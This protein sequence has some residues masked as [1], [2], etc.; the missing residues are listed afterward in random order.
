MPPIIALVAASTLFTAAA[1]PTAASQIHPE[2]PTLY[3]PG[4]PVI[5]GE[6]AAIAIVGLEPG[7]RVRFVAERANLWGQ[8]R[9]W[10][11]EAVFIADPV[12]GV[13]DP[14][15]HAP[16]EGDWSRADRFAFLWSMQ[17]TNMD[18][19]AETTR[20]RVRL[21]AD[22][23]MDG[24][25]EL[26]AYLD[27]KTDGYRE[28]DASAL[29]PGAFLYRPVG[30]G[31]F[32]AIIFLGGSEGGDRAARDQAP[33]LAQ[34]GYAVLGLP[35]YSPDWYGQGRAIPELPEA[36]VDIPVTL[37][38][39]ARDWLA[40]RPDIDAGAIGLFGISKGAEFALAAASYLGGFN[41]V[42]AIVPSDMIW[43]GW[44]AGAEGERSSFSLNGE[45]LA[46]VPYKDM[47][48]TLNARAEGAQVSIRT[49]HDEGRAANP[50][51][52]EAARIPVE[53]IEAPVFLLGGMADDVW[54][55]GLMAVNIAERRAATQ[56][57]TELYVY[58]DAGHGLS[59]PPTRPSRA[60]E[61]NAKSEAYPAFL[62]FLD[63]ALGR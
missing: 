38:A 57:P 24:T 15:R 3:A 17:R 44:G 43:E 20:S 19:P 25:F 14:V 42:A 11:S 41:A 47:R 6:P 50:D 8:G 18:A 7:Q 28:I 51:R 52:V 31:P 63:R 54:A 1:A 23:D 22:I 33:G 16:V 10:R 2:T 45:P 60:A 58:A 56:L 35:Y 53:R 49:P 48:A 13:A 27:F 21:R 37:A 59:G 5:E 26:E 62:A 46:F 4:D 30:E 29:S 40:E 34:R 39:E 32:P 12:Y 61:A 9:L 36:F 55:S